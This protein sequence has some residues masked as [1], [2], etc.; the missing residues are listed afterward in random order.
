M[1]MGRHLDGGPVFNDLP[2][3]V[4]SWNSVAD[5]YITD[6]TATNLGSKND[7]LEG[8]VI[9]GYLKPLDPSFTD[10]GYEDDIYFMIVNGLSDATGLASEASQQI[11]LDFNFLAS[12]ITSLERLNR[13]T[14]L[15]EPVSLIFDGGSLYH[16]DLIL[17]GGTGDLFKFNNPGTFVSGP[18]GYIPPLPGD[19]NDDG[20]V[21]A[22]DVSRSI[23][24]WGMTGA[25]RTDGDLNADGIVGEADYALVK[26]YWAWGAGTLPPEPPGPTPEPATL[27][28]LGLG[29][30]A[31][32]LKRRP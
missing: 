30:L 4:S 14:G 8:D 13:D 15:I 18:S 12:G 26:A 32:L 6:I 25:S 16:L 10:P 5:P 9:V 2:A 17:D 21:G 29:G 27:G 20:L 3:G 24:S 11:R 31:A 7:G 1:K 28:M 22:V 19:V 23:T